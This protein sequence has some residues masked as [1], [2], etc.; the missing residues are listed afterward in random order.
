MIALFFNQLRTNSRDI[1][2]RCQDWQAFDTA[3][4][5]SISSFRDGPL[6]NLWGGG[7]GGRSTKKIFAQGKIERKKNPWTPINP[8]K[9][10]C[11]GLKMIH[12]RNLITKKYSCGSKIPLPSPITFLMVRP[13]GNSYY[14]LS[15]TSLREHPVFSALVCGSQANYLPF[16]IQCLSES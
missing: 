14:L 6:E 12:T 15:F 2:H 9:Y 1:P 4:D 13:L 7:G 5:L 16:S 3:P 8:K 10:S 11:Y